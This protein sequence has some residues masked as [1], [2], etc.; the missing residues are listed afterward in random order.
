MRLR[1]IVLVLTAGLLSMEGICQPMIAKYE[2]SAPYRWL[3]KEVLESSLLDNMET[4]DNWIPF[5]TGAQ[6]IIDARRDNRPDKAGQQ[7]SEMSLSNERARD[8][9]QSLRMR[10]PTKLDIPGP[11]NGRGWGTA[12]V[13]RQFDHE[14]WTGSNRISLW[15]Y[16]DNPGSYVNWIELRIYND[17][18]EKLPAL[19][20]QEGETSLML[21]NHEWN[22][23]VWEISNVARDKITSLEISYYLAGNAPEATDTVTFFIDQLELQKVVPDHIEGWDVWPGR[24]SF[25]HSGY[26]S[27]A[28]KTAIANALE[29]SEF[30]VIN[31]E[32]GQSVLTKSIETVNSHLGN[33][34]MMDFSEVWQPGKYILEAGELRTNSFSIGPDAWRE[35]ILKALNF[36]YVERCG[37]AVPGVHGVCHRDWI[38]RHGDSQIVVN[39][40]WHDAGDLTQSF[41]HT[42][43]A[44]YAMLNLAEGLKNKNRD[45]ELYERLLEEAIWGLDWILKTSFR[46]G[47]RFGGAAS[48]RKTN[49]IIGDHDDL[50]ARAVNSPTDHFMASASEALAYRILE[51]DDPRLANFALEMA[52]EDWKYGLEGLSELK[53]PED[54]PVFRGTFDSGFVE[55]DIVSYGILASVELWKATQNKAYINKAVEWAQVI[56]NSQQRTK[57]DWDIPFTGFFYTSTKKDH[58]LHYVHRGNE[59]GPILALTL[60][61]TLFP[62]HP[63]WM[64]WYSSVVLHSE[65]Q[66]KIALYTEPYGVMPA[67]IYNDKEYLLA[68]E[69]RRQSFQ[70]QVLNGIPL[71]KGH[72]LRLF[73]VW[74]D[75]RGHFGVI[76]PQAQALINAG[77]LRGDIESASLAQHQLEWVIGRNPFSQSTMWGEG[78]DFAPQY[79]VMSGD[80]VGGLPVGIQTKGDSDVPYW[81]V[82]NSWTYKEIWVRPVIR[83]LWLMHDM[84]GPAQLEISADDPVEMENLSTG[85]KILANESGSAGSIK[86]S[87]PE[88][89]Y[90]IKSKNEEYYRTFLPASSYKLDLSSG[91]VRDIKVSVNTNDKGEIVIRADAIG[92]GSHQ[93]RIRSS[94][95]SLSHPEKTLTLKNGKA[96]SLEWRCRITNSDMPWVAVI[97]PDNDNSLRKEIHGSAWE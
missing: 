56:V 30:N 73:P 80:M 61:C 35:S 38:C 7:I 27:G 19:F 11:K 15:M 84:A 53:T 33:Y 1:I 12:G 26:Q 97:I 93:F 75:Y 21:R 3:S 25:S 41:I 9:G 78:Y 94:N 59:Q 14:D 85:Q 2:H 88:G 55:H 45:Q 79:S 77:K 54:K 58:I 82:Q 68:P 20:G 50:L 5:T 71:G 36:F 47:Y 65:Y 42:S 63:D 72:Y 16:P 39:G 34:Q 87:I 76:L 96:G 49:G 23:V 8:D 91:K 46:D 43:E 62:D 74:M 92:E 22:H 60:L 57:P 28:V 10:L 24:I 70:E 48:S 31:Q 4:L 95:L 69:S 83:W 17:G 89:D 40:G 64:G 29:A 67:S 81:P 37:Y 90:R 44:V 86:L 18:E 66:K 51:E 6:Q 52:E 32:T 13:R